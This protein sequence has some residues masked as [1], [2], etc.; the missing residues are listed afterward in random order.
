MNEMSEFSKFINEHAEILAVEIVE[1]VLKGIN[2]AIPAWEKEQ[3]VSM[4]FDFLGFFGKSLINQNRESVPDGLMEW[5]KKNA[6]QVAL[7]GQISEIAMRYPITREVITDI[8]TRISIEKGLSVKENAYIIKRLNAMLDISLMETIY[9]FERITDAH[10]EEMQKELAK[11]SAPLVPVSNGVVVLPIIGIIDSFR[12][13]YITEHVIPKV[14]ALN[15]EKVIIDFSG[16]YIITE[17]NSRYFHEIG[18]MLRLMGIEVFI[19][20]LRPE[21]VQVVIKGAINNITRN[22]SFSNVQQALKSIQ[23]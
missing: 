4:Y 15:I 13:N 11:S 9:A 10:K 19:T 2:L 20:G 8:I 21:L 5:S 22:N 14:A 6:E 18:E 16:V 3:A 17:E 7:E 23:K 1:N 12:V